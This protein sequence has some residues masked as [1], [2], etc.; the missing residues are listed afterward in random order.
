[1]SLKRMTCQLWQTGFVSVN[2]CSVKLH[3]DEM[4]PS[5]AMS[6]GYDLFFGKKKKQPFLSF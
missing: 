2:L 1:M 4:C 6:M 3:A 5:W